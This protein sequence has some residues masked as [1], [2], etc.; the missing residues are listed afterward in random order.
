MIYPGQ[1]VKLPLAEQDG[2][3]NTLATTLGKPQAV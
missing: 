1:G 3:C 2:Q